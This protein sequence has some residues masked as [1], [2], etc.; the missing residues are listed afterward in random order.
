MATYPDL[1]PYVYSEPTNYRHLR[2]G[3]ARYD[4]QRIVNQLI[5]TA[6]NVGWIGPEEPFATGG[7]CPPEFLERL[8][9]LGE[10]AQLAHRGYHVCELGSCQ[11][12]S[13]E[14]P[15]PAADR[16]PHTLMPG[17]G[18]IFV[19]GNRGRS[20]AAPN[21]IPHYVRDHQ[22]RP[23]EEFIDAVMAIDPCHMTDTAAVLKGVEPRLME[24]VDWPPERFA[25]PFRESF[26]TTSG[27]EYTVEFTLF[28]GLETG[29]GIEARIQARSQLAHDPLGQGS[30][31]RGIDYPA[32][33]K[34]HPPDGPW[35]PS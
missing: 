8:R 31:L 21:L 7:D 18:I 14:N 22:Y 2:P 27:Q 12:F 34:P 29:S 3:T 1:S 16:A 35:R 9:R 19:P 28:D 13:F 15:G 33:W 23:P 25:E 5:R 26:R 20:Y 24:M 32:G 10:R 17:S 4:Q 6:V 30:L 11:Q